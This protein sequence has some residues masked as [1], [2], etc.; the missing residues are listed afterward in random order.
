MGGGRLDI[1]L[2]AS[3]GQ[4]F[5]WRQQENGAWVGSDG[6]TWYRVFQ[7]D[8]ETLGVETNG[9]REDFRHYFRLDWDA[10]EIEREIL[11]QGP[12]LEP[13]MDALR[14]LRLLRPYS[15][16][17]AF[18]GFLCTP[19]NNLTRIT[20]MN[21]YLSTLAPMVTHLD[22]VAVHSFPGTEMIADLEDSSLREAGFGYRAAT[23]PAVA[24]Q[25]RERGGDAY[26]IGLRRVKYEVARADLMTIKGIGPKLA[27]CIC[28]FALNHTEAVPV[29]THIW[30]AAT[31]LF[32]PQWRNESLTPARYDAIGDALRDKFGKRAGWAQQYLF[33]DNLLNWRSRA[34]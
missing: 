18:Y 6:P 32:F 13:Y 24:Q 19:N 21:R 12:E 11:E 28:L 20:A 30:Q 3:S 27:D 5:R 9:E 8:D 23:I 25:V 15:A 10:I 34:G 22:G 14:G 1:A 2:C 16:V 26:I 29:D 7:L 33:Y 31:R 17:E 4:A